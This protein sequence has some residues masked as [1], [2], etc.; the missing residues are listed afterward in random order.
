[1][2]STRAA[3]HMID[4]LIVATW[5]QERVTLGMAYPACLTSVNLA[6]KSMQ[7]APF[8]HFV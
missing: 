6:S 2:R 8:Q 3:N 4:M 7:N 5:V 1:M